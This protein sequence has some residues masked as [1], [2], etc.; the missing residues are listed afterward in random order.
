MGKRIDITNNRFG[1]LVA[2][3]KAASSGGKNPRSKWQC[4]CD[5]GK[6]LNVDTSNLTRGRAKSCGCLHKE[7]V[8][9]LK[10]THGMSN[11]EAYKSWRA[12]WARCTIKT[13][14]SY[15]SYGAKGVTVCERW[16]SFENFYEDMGERLSGMSIDRIDNSIGYQPNNCKW[17]TRREQDSNKRHIGH[18]SSG[19]KNGNNKLVET[20]VLRIKSMLKIGISG[21]DIAK[22]FGVTKHTISC[23]KRNK[24]W[25]HVQGD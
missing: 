17:S 1:R 2:I 20:D 25:N 14:A 15:K 10:I 4:I 9:G 5:C 11:T 21:V 6:T 19:S 3:G 23:I 22:Q 12:M 24:T 13:N 18:D 7:V 16:K 8:G